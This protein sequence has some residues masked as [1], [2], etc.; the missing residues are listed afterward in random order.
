VVGLRV[1]Q[2][3]EVDGAQVFRVDV[4]GAGAQGAQHD[5][6]VAQALLVLGGTGT[7]GGLG[8]DFAED[9]GFGE[10]LG[11]DVQAGVGICQR[12]EQDAAEG[13]QEQD[14]PAHGTPSMISG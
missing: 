5:G 3:L 9:V 13:E 10:A 1:L 6:G 8:Q 4:D 14:K 12:G 11:A 2:D 7:G